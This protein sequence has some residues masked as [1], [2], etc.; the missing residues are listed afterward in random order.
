MEPFES[1]RDFT[2]TYGADGF[3]ASWKS[4]NAAE[5]FPEEKFQY[6]TLHSGIELL[7]I[8]CNPDV[9]SIPIFEIDQTPLE[10]G[11]HFSGKK[12]GHITYCLGRKEEVYIEPGK[13]VISFK[14]ESRCRIEKLGR[15]RTRALN[16][17]L[18]PQLLY[19]LL[20]EELDQ[21]PPDLRSVL[22][23]TGRE[24]FN[25]STD[26]TPRIRMTLDQML[27][28]PYQGVLRQMYLE[29]K[30]FEVIAHLLSQLSDPK[31][32]P[33]NQ[34][35]LHPDDIDR[36]HRAK[37]ILISDMEN[38]PSLLE[39][40]RKVG[41]NDTKLKRGFRQV[42]GT[43]VFGFF[44]EHRINQA[45]ELLNRGKLSLDEIAYSSGYCDTS[46]FIKDFSRHFGTT[47]G[48][49]LKQSL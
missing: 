17:Y 13:C 44:R 28:C 8:D 9:M 33:G 49:Y 47:P 37:D 1:S 46:H 25:R 26:I 3:G 48:N 4:L 27:D 35:R 45:R 18:S 22:D 15:Q 42:F 21:V 7:F 38:R 30:A 43:T 40:A 6:L 11:F 2:V 14:P 29:G 34:P 20:N 39:L 32:V 5:R 12:R 10:F 36:I 24:P 41:L 23:G 19:T 31:A 16:V